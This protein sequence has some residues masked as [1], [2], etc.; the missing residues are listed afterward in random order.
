[1]FGQRVHIRSMGAVGVVWSGG[2]ARL[3]DHNC[4]LQAIQDWLQLIVLAV[5]AGIIAAGTSNHYYQR[6]FLVGH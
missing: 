4:L 6:P 2:C 5:T 3:V 1:M